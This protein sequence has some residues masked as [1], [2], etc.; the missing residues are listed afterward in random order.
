MQIFIATS[1]WIDSRFLKHHKYWTIGETHLGYPT[2][3]QSQGDVAARQVL[4]KLLAAAHLPALN[5]CCPRPPDLT[6]VLGS[7]GQ[8]LQQDKQHRSIQLAKDGPI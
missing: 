7:C 1:R 3:S 5:D 2:L 8:E 6:F 4:C